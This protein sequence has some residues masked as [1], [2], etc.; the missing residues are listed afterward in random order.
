MDNELRVTLKLEKKEIFYKG[1]YRI[2]MNP[3]L[4]LFI[5]KNSLVSFFKKRESKINFKVKLLKKKKVFFIYKKKNNYK[6]LIFKFIF[7][8]KN[9]F[10]NIFNYD[11][12]L[13]HIF[14]LGKI[15]FF[16]S[17]KKIKKGFN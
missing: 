17:K 2:R 14:S 13:L 6:Y 9:I 3:F 11:Y 7:T 8:K 10:V 4:N 16:K 12:K 5:Y 1:I 15:G